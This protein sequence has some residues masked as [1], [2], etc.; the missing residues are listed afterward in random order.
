MLATINE[1]KKEAMRV[2]ISQG[3]A[4]ENVWRKGNDVVILYSQTNKRNNI[5][6]DR[7]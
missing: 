3:G 5:F 2:R 7:C 1:K 4:H 6:K